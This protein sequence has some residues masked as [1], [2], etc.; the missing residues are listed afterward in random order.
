MPV[1]F[2]F[3][4]LRFTGFLTAVAVFRLVEGVV[5]RGMGFFLGGGGTFIF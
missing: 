2:F 5:L 4:G 1:F 3:D